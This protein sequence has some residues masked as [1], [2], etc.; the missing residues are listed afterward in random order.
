MEERGR[1]WGR[2]GEEEDE[3]VLILE[4]LSLLLFN[5]P[6]NPLCVSISVPGL[7]AVGCVS[8]LGVA[9]A[10]THAAASLDVSAPLSAAFTIAG[11]LPTDT[12]P[13]T[14]TRTETGWN[15]A[16]GGGVCV[17]VGWP[18]LVWGGRGRGGGGAERVD[19]RSVL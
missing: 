14:N 4:G 6:P 2:E 11:V 3:R 7:T 5:N 9:L 19:Q 12:P 17:W 18:V 15:R 13:H 1:G 8:R 16:L 10:L